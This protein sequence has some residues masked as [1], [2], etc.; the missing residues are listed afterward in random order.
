MVVVAAAVLV[1]VL[2][3]VIRVMLAVLVWAVL[4]TVLPVIAAVLTVPATLAAHDIAAGAAPL[5]AS[6]SRVGVNEGGGERGSKSP[7]SKHS[8]STVGGVFWPPDL[9][10]RADETGPDTAPLLGHG[11]RHTERSATQ[12]QLCSKTG[13]KK[14]ARGGME[15]EDALRHLLDLRA[16]DPHLSNLE[17]DGEEEFAAM[18]VAFDRLATWSKKHALR[19]KGASSATG[20]GGTASSKRKW[21]LQPL[22]VEKKPIRHQSFSSF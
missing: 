20:A 19:A 21:V 16:S 1:V 12:A 18:R 17:P 8:A 4:V 14:N 6:R 11:E 2:V 13:R 5:S 15:E 10:C 22:P 9:L 7:P 3:D